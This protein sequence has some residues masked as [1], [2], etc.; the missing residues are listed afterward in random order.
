MNSSQQAL[1]GG[2]LTGDEPTYAMLL[3]LLC[4]KDHGMKV[5]ICLLVHSVA[6]CTTTTRRF[7]STRSWS[8]SS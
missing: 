2:T 7:D 3:L 4:Q 5:S 1:H 6:I 8:E